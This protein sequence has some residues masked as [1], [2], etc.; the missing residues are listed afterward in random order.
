MTLGSLLVL[1]LAIELLKAD[2]D[3]LDGGE[4]QLSLFVGV[5]LMAFSQSAHCHFVP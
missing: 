2:C 3:R 5:G 4:L 1:W